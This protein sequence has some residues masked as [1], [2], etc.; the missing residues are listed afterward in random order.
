MTYDRYIPEE[1]WTK[2]VGKGSL[3]DVTNYFR[4]KSVVEGCNPSQ[5]YG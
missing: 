3:S 2:W 4:D 5:Q 1:V